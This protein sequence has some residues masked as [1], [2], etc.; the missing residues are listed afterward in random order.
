MR[1]G[2][3]QL[4][5]VLAIALAVSG[6]TALLTFWAYYANHTLGLTVSYLVPLGSALLIGF[7]LWDWRPRAERVRQLAVPLGLWALS[8]AF[9]VY[10][11]FLHGGSGDALATA[12]SRFSLGMPSD[13]VIPAY[14]AEWFYLHGHHGTPPLFPPEWLASDRPPLQIGYALAQRPWFWDQ[15]AVD[16][17]LIGVGLQQLWVIGLWAL[18]SAAKV[19]RL[20]IGL[21]AIA[22]LF[23]GLVLVNGIYVWPKLLPAAMLLA[24]AA[25][26]LTPLW[27]QAR[28]DWRL[29]ALLGV[30]ASL[31]M[32]GHGSSVFALIPLALIAIVR[33]APGWKWLGA[34]VAVAIVL[35]AP[36]SAYQKWGDP[37]GNRLDRW[38]L[39]GRT[40]VSDES[41]ADAVLDAYGEAGLGGALHDKGQNLV[42]IA[43]GGPAFDQAEAVVE[44]AGDGDARTAFGLS[45]QILF[46]Y[47]LPSL[48]LLLLTPL[49]MLVGRHRIRDR[50]EWRFAL[51]AYAALL[52]GALAWAL[53]LFG[54]APA[55][56]VVHQGSYL[57][58][59]LGLAAGAVGLRAVYPRFAPWYVI[60]AALLTLALYVP[61]WEYPEGSSYSAGSIVLA[62]LFAA[63][64]CAL[65]LGA[66][67]ALFRTAVRST[68]G[69]RPSESDPTSPRSRGTS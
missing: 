41:T 51:F 27:P 32:L 47:L 69:T 29:A 60:A 54:S 65:A 13:N 48:G 8:S 37:P 66:S 14:F 21:A 1:V 35:M 63:L 62:A 22:A 34:G 28:R 31:A 17:Q 5:L 33:G 23:S 15:S 53:I 38:F 30:L 10:F 39:A 26:I 67:P 68:R 57:L 49:L 55:R 58:P 64:F 46:F 43:G 2:V 19:R 11:G 36:W 61:S 24:A 42:A 25:L 44:A 40:E 56:T 45:R 20:T 16:Y 4:P 50:D 7:T 9:L 6:C 3:R 59:L 52:V 18:L 12:S